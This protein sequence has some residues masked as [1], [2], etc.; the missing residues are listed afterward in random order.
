MVRIEGLADDDSEA[1]KT[2][3][4]D[5]CLEDRFRMRYIWRTGDVVAWDNAASMHS[6]TTKELDPAKHRTLWRATISGGPAF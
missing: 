3:I 6:A 5:H 4:Y 1:L 2:E